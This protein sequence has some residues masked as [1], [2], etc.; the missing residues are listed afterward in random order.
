MNET[1]EVNGKLTLW[2]DGRRTKQPMANIIE[3]LSQN[4]RGAFYVDA[5]CTDCDLCRTLAPAFFK[6]D[7]DIGFSVVYRQPETE[8]EKALAAEARDSCPTESIGSDGLT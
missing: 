5:T 1:N 7:D 3:R 6:R 2:H 8:E 4:I